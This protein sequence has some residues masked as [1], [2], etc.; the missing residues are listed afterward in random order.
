[1]RT[2]WIPFTALLLLASSTLAAQEREIR[3]A[4]LP[5]ELESRLLR[6]YD[7]SATRRFE[8]SAY[9]SPREIINGDVGALHGTLR[10]AGRVHGDLAMV[11]GDVVLE[12]TAVIT[13]DVIVVGGEVRMED[14]AD[15]EGSVTSY[16]AMSGRRSTSRRAQARRPFWDRGYSRLTLRA[17]Y[18]Y[19]RVEGLPIMFGPMI[20]TGGGMPLRLEALAIWRS[21]AGA[22]L[23]PDRFGYLVKAEQF[24][25]GERDFSVGGSLY[26]V[27]QAM[28]PWQ[29]SDLEASLGAAIFRDD[30][31]DYYDR[32]G[33]NA[34][35]RTN[36]VDEFDLRVEYRR[37]DHLAVPAESP[38]SLL[39]RG[40]PWRI[41][42][43]AAE[44]DVE[45][46]AGALTLDFRDDDK[47]PYSGWYVTAEIEKALNGELIRPGVAVQPGQDAYFPGGAPG[48]LAD[49]LYDADFTTGLIDIRRYNPVGYRSQLNLRVV[50]GGS[51]TDA[52]LPPQYQHALGGFGTLPGYDLFEADCG[53]HLVTGSRDMD[54]LARLFNP[55]YGCDRFALIQA[56]YRGSLTLDLGFGDPD[57]D[58]N[59]GDWWID[60]DPN[61]VVFF[62]A[63]RGW[64]NDATDLS[65][66]ST[67]TDWL[68]DAGVG[69]LIDDFGFYVALPLTEGGGGANFFFRLQ[70]RF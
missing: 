25:T 65:G 48:S 50:G 19:N 15:V 21:E 12:R 47:D 28:D 4:N 24:F 5:Y 18:N 55:S 45:T 9:V 8:G 59:W 40:Q 34:F 1:M 20:Q 57:W 51:L 62:D 7:R 64:T 60:F 70:R 68:Y 2:R 33:W 35:V 27:V 61:W 17:G 29:L 58:D 22:E 10:M 6:L 49:R 32:T 67:G 46:V 39:D 13:G 56:E 52:S 37:E 42:P 54:G 53:A 41:Q 69:F 3:D 14:G 38:W 16:G 30:F 26:S 36:P 43:V 23:E 31:R 66:V 11:G 44:G 63:G